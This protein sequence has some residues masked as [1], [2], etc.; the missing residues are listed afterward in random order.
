MAAPTPAAIHGSRVAAR[1]LRVLLQAYSRELDSEAR[2]R[3]RRE[4]EELTS[5]LEPAREADVAQRIILRLARNRNGHIDGDSRALLERA[6]RRHESEVE[7]LRAITAGAHWQQ[8]LTDLR[9]LFALST[10]AR[11]KRRDRAAARNL[12]RKLKL[13]KCRQL[14]LFKKHCKA[15]TQ[16]CCA[17]RLDKTRI[18][19]KRILKK[20]ITAD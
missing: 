4:L 2:K 18:L 7:T 8:R 19:K 16:E 9:Q 10:L 12:R 13:Q 3:C 11:E 17:A 14:H 5:D 15:L 6:V 20:Q 1:R